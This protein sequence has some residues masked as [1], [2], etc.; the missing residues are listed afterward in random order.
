MNIEK[1]ADRSDV[2]N[3]IWNI[4]MPTEPSDVIIGKSEIKKTLQVL[5]AGIGYCLAN[6]EPLPDGSR[7]VEIH[8]GIIVHARLKPEHA[9]TA[10]GHEFTEPSHWDIALKFEAGALRMISEYL[11]KQAKNE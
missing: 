6:S 10:F 1:E 9:G 2:I 5:P 7:R 11:G 4:A 3:A 8:D